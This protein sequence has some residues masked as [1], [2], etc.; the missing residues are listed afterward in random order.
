M[1][2]TTE[3][4][5]AVPPSTTEPA[6]ATAGAAEQKSEPVASEEGKSLENGVE[7]AATAAAPQPAAT[8]GAQDRPLE[9]PKAAPVDIDPSKPTVLI[10][11]G[12]GM[13]VSCQLARHILLT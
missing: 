10:I 3:Q 6:Q 13:H 4:S 5:S 11:G 9:Q 1:A 8:D 7:T 2:D 12:L